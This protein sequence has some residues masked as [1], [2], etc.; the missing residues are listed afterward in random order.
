[1]ISEKNV[2]NIMFKNVMDA[3][4]A[5][6]CYWLLGY[7][8][9]YGDG[10][11]GP[12]IGGANFALTAEEGATYHNFFFQWAFAATAATIVC[13]SVA[14]RCRLEAYFVYSVVSLSHRAPHSTT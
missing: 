3:S 5:G 2:I 8:I 11:D 1:M 4:I 9:A 14:E 6:I 7:G 13:G 12:F 10:N